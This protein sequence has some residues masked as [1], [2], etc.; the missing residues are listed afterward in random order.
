MRK[1][2]YP[3]SP[4]IIVTI[5]L[6]ELGTGSAQIPMPL[7]SVLKVNEPTN[8][9]TRPTG[10]AVPSKSG[11]GN[12]LKITHIQR[13]GQIKTMSKESDDAARIQRGIEEAAR[14]AARDAELARQETARRSEA[15]RA[16]AA[17]AAA[18]RAANAAKR[19]K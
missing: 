19:N 14:R 12:G 8:R 16:S 2:H 17:K 13:K 7:K 3:E 6:R 18:T 10:C 5:R 11:H 15:A 1:L 4:Q 9:G